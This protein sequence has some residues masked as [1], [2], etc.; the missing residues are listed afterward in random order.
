MLLGLNNLGIL[1]S[2]EV[3]DDIT[4]VLRIVE[5]SLNSF[6]N[7][8]LVSLVQETNKEFNNLPSR[9]LWKRRIRGWF[10]VKQGKFSTKVGR[11][12]RFG[13]QDGGFSIR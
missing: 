10:L 1:D 6:N 8:F 3:L 7:H 12:S 4:K 13:E 5:S 11:S 9:K 2:R